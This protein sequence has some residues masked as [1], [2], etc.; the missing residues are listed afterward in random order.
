MMPPQ[1]A[2]AKRRRSRHLEPRPTVELLPAINVN[3]LRNVIPRDYSSNIYSNPFRYPQVRHIRLW[4]R[5]I[6]IVDR[7]DRVQVFAIEWIKT[8][9]GAPRAIF[10][11]SCG[12]G[13]IRLFARYGTYA[14][15]ACHRAVHMCQRQ[16]SKGRKRLRAC[17][18]RLELGGLPDIKEAPP[19][20]A[21]WRHRR[22]YQRV[23][24]QV[25][26]LEMAIGPRRFRKPLDMRV[27]AYQVS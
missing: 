12:Y 22:T 1:L 27:F 7:F 2:R 21:K 6:E 23:R 5:R 4:C 17:K 26:A 9:F 10:V 13:A 18:L 15:K 20:K 11:C 14:C 3:D 25:R 19:P 8:G 24:D 16:N